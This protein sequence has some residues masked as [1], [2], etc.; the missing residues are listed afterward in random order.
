M[1]A[2]ILAVGGDGF[3]LVEKGQSRSVIVLPARARHVEK[4]AAEELQHHI[5]LITGCEIPV[6]RENKLPEEPAKYIYLGDTEAARKLNID[7]KSLP[8]NSTVQKITGDAVYLFGMDGN[9]VVP[10]DET[11]PMGTLFA[12]YD[13]LNQQ[14]GVRWLWPGES[15]IYVRKQDTVYSGT[16]R[17]IVRAQKLLH[18]RMRDGSGLGNYDKV[19]SKE[20]YEQ[21]INERRVWLRRHQFACGTSFQY[22]HAYEKYW[23]RFGESHPEYFALRTNG[24]REP[25]D[26]K[27]SKLIQMCVSNPELQKQ[28]I[29]DWTK[30]VQSYKGPFINGAEN[31]KTAADEHC[32]CENCLAWD[33][34]SNRMTAEEYLKRA[35]KDSM[36]NILSDRYA[37]FWL[38]LQQEG[39]KHRENPVVLGYAYADYSNPPLETALNENI[40][41]AI[42]PGIQ[43]PLEPDRRKAMRQ[44]WDG[45][46][47]TGARL[48]LRPNYFLNGYTLPYIYA[49]QFGEDYKHAYDNGM[50]GTD[51]DS[52][53]GMFGTQGPNLYMV[54][55]LT[56]NPAMKVEDV[57]DEYYS[58]FG[59]AAPKIKAYFELWESATGGYTRE[60][61]GKY[62]GGGWNYAGWSGHKLYP[63]ELIATAEKILSEAR[64]AV[65]DNPDDARRVEFLAKGLKHTRLT[66]ET[67][68]AFEAFSKNR[69]SAELK[70]KFLESRH[71]LDEYRQEIRNDQ[72]I[73]IVITVKLE[74]WM[75]WNIRK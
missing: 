35:G 70:E 31:D 56:D 44:Q 1:L 69:K 64:L 16:P 18:T 46:R 17:E 36:P 50:V 26:P 6:A 42:V 63:M 52:L 34:V 40:I 5:K 61:A 74:Q 49:R 47:A 54:A 43:Y 53:T 65:R 66:L 39:A 24:K 9:G 20:E 60:F 48:Y 4:Y 37:K 41:V 67:M 75:G 32:F 73:N 19:M 11:T 29:E 2:N 21:A 25:A 27:R 71:L 28:I 38:A 57:L 8:I 51:F 22:G 72:V 14:L 15:G 59:K 55:R 33:P 7:V 58:S 30:N 13:F 62:P 12:V 68:N 23:E 3:P 45:W 10:N